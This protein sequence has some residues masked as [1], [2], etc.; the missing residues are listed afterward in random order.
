MLRAA[1]LGACSRVPTGHVGAHRRTR[2][3]QGYRPKLRQAVQCSFSRIHARLAKEKQMEWLAA[4]PEWLVWCA[5]GA[6][7]AVALA[8]LAGSLAAVFDL[9]SRF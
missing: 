4:V 9:E 8:S 5:A 1:G 3:L 7:G 2:P 6:V